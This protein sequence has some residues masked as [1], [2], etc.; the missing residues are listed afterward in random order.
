MVKAESYEPT[1][2]HMRHPSG[3]QIAKENAAAKP[4]E[5][6]R[7]EQEYYERYRANQLKKVPSS[8]KKEDFLADLRLPNV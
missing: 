5:Y 4:T 6:S 7:N 3:N 8:I 2:G 1:P